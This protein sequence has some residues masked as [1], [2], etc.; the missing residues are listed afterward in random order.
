MPK[1][2]ASMYVHTILVHVEGR[3]L[4]EAKY[5]STHY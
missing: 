4:I 2:V 1:Y 3:G 5:E